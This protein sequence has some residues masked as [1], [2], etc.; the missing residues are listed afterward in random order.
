MLLLLLD[1]IYCDTLTLPVNGAI[2]STNSS[3]TTSVSFDCAEYYTINSSLV[4]ICLENG[5]NNVA[6]GEIWNGELP[7]C[8]LSNCSNPGI[9]V[10]GRSIGD[11]RLSFANGSTVSF[12]CNTGYH[13]Y[14]ATDTQCLEGTWSSTIPNCTLI[15]CPSPSSPKNGRFYPDDSNSFPFN[16]TVEFTCR[17]RYSLTNEYPLICLANGTWNASVPKCAAVPTSSINNSTNSESDT[18]GNNFKFLILGMVLTLFLFLLC[19]ICLL[20]IMLIRNRPKS[21]SATATSDSCK[22][23]FYYMHTTV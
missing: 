20:T 22:S 16:T 11:E 4:L 12:E 23:L 17:H 13:L 3:Y 1:P 18:L 9:P 8:T 2:N 5:W 21:N 6:M 14:G 7:I 10:N 19:I 15:T